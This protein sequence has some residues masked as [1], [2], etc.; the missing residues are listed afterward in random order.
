MNNVLDEEP[1]FAIGDGDGDLYGY[2]M[3]THNPMGRYAYIKLN[4]NF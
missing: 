2:V 1:P 4:I 3:A